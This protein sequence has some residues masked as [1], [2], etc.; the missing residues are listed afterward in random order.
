MEGKSYWQHM[1]YAVCNTINISY[2][3]N[4]IPDSSTSLLQ[5]NTW[6]ANCALLINQKYLT[7]HQ[8]VVNHLLFFYL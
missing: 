3:I 5:M 2:L 4:H 1:I 7:T 6:L 8:M